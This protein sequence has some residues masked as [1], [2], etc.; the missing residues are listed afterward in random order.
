[1]TKPENTHKFPL[2]ESK[3]ELR[4][5]GSQSALVRGPAMTIPS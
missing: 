3:E 2:H 1:M 4:R 5:L